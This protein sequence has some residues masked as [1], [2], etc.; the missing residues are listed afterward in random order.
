MRAS[1][2]VGRVGGLAV[3]LGI[4]AAVAVGGAAVCWADDGADTGRADSTR[5]QQQRQPSA[6]AES[7]RRGD[8]SRVAASARL[9][10]ATTSLPSTPPPPGAP[11]ESP[12]SWAVAAVARR[13]ATASATASATGNPVLSFFFN[14]T[15]VLNPSRTGQDSASVVTGDLNIDDP[16]SDVEIYTVTRQPVN[17]TVTVDGN[18]EY[19]YTPN[20]P[21]N[22][23]G[24]TDTFEVN[25]SDA[26]NGFHIH[27]I[28]GL[29]NLLTFGLIGDPGHA[30]TSTVTVVV[31][32]RNIAPVGTVS[33]S[34]PDPATGRVAGQVVGS[35][36][37]GDP[38][39]YS[40]SMTTSKGR[41]VVA[42]D[43]TFT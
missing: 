39:T 22:R 17:G 6:R 20:P 13:S 43:G 16:D 30:T 11:V 40:G 32:P 25:V 5:A 1:M 19:T 7:T 14:Q 18:G 42:A 33:M 10:S 24:T 2:A 41:V 27:G 4:G 8:R 21:Y 28:G 29:I 12:V 35:D 9:A 23:S 15:P 36:A 34:A 38:L 37:D 26:D 31:D 3:A